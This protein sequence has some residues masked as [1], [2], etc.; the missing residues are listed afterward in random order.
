MPL[1][2]AIDDS[3]VRIALAKR[4]AMIYGVADRIEFILG[5]YFAFARSYMSQLPQRQIIDVV[6]LSP[7][8]GGPNYLQGSV[9]DVEDE[10]TNAILQSEYSLSNIQPKDGST[11][12][13]VTRRITHNIAFYLPRNVNLQEVSQLVCKPPGGSALIDT[14]RFTEE[15]IE[16]EEE[17]MSGKLKAV[18]CYFGGL[19]SGQ[20]EMF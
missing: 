9:Q 19:V 8:W 11:L 7:P 3:P 15:S 18:T 14:Q 4:N 6:F 13:K 16:V 17:Y 5:D 2:I 1:V 20:E 10:N 12:F